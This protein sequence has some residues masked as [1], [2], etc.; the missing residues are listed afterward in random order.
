MRSIEILFFVFTYIRFACYI[1]AVIMIGSYS[2]LFSIN[3]WKD[4]HTCL[5]SFVLMI[6]SVISM[7]LGVA[8][9]YVNSK[10]LIITDIFGIISCITS[11]LAFEIEDKNQKLKQFGK[12]D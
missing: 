5:K 3:T 7:I 12:E 1:F 2:V 11:A 8:I 4:E 9:G 6:I 10:F